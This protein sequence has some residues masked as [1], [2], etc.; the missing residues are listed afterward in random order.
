MYASL[1]LYR[2]VQWSPILQEIHPYFAFLGL[3]VQS[4]HSPLLAV[5][6]FSL[7]FALYLA[8]NSSS[9]A[10]SSLLATF[11]KFLGHVRVRKII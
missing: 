6:D 5:F 10:I 2:L 1:W 4:M 11:N 8:I 7:N 3:P 9:M